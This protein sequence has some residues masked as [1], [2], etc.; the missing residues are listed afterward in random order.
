MSSLIIKGQ[1]CSKCVDQKG[2]PDA[3]KLRKKKKKKKMLHRVAQIVEP[4]C[5]SEDSSPVSVL[6]FDQFII[7]HDVP[8]SGWCLS[9][10]FVF[11]S[12]PHSINKFFCSSF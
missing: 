10:L 12:I 11:K 5:S 4:E 9:I 8:T 7:D 3:A 6:D 2:V 1:E